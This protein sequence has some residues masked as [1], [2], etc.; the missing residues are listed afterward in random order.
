MTAGAPTTT[1]IVYK[2]TYQLRWLQMFSCSTDGRTRWFINMMI[3]ILQTGCCQ[4]VVSLN[5]LWQK[6]VVSVCQ[7]PTKKNPDNYLHARG[8]M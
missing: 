4:F 1:F 6:V 5:K 3:L 2:M 7:A 8:P